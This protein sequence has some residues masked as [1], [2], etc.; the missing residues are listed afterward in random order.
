MT[1][2]T[3]L[4]DGGCIWWSMDYTND[5]KYGGISLDY[6]S[7]QNLGEW[8][9]EISQGDAPGVRCKTGISNAETR[10]TV[11]VVSHAA[12]SGVYTITAKT[13]GEA[14]VESVAEASFFDTGKNGNLYIG[15]SDH[16]TNRFFV[17]NVHEIALFDRVISADEIA[18][19]LNAVN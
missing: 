9:V 12:G 13:E 16:G 19:Y 10:R 7:I 18:E 8:Y 1:P 4:S 2:G 14:A 6:W 3:Q 17:G 15:A 5:Y 11:F